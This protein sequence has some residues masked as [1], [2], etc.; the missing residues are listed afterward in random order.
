[1]LLSEIIKLE[2][3][4]IDLQAED[5]DDALHKI[6][7]LFK[8]SRKFAD[9]SEG[10]IYKGLKDREALGSTGFGNGIAIPHCALEG[11]DKFAISLAVCKKGV[12][13]DSTDRRKTKIFVTIL[14][15]KNFP[16]EHLKLLAACSHILKQPGVVEELLQSTSRINLYEEFL[17]NADNGSGQI[18]G[19]GKE[20]LL[21]LFV[22]DDHILQDITEVFVEYGIQRSIIINTTEMENLISKVPLFMGFFNFTGDKNPTSKIVL[23]KIAEDHIDAIVTGLEDIYGDLN[24][25][26]DLDVMVLDAFYTKGF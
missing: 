18:V 24:A 11:L 13:F 19:E 2:A 5:K 16:N 23:A 6:A 9:I 26:S 10:E 15:P 3:C 20:K 8:R 4:T 7:A 21:M 1:M 17:E 14:G 22:K 12:N 25:F